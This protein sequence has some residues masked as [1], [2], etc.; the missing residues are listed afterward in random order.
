MNCDSG[1]YC[2]GEYAEGICEGCAGIDMPCSNGLECCWGNH[3][4]PE[5]PVV[6]PT[7]SWACLEMS[8]EL[9]TPG[10]ADGSMRFWVDDEL[11]HEATGIRWRDGSQLQLNRAMLEHYIAPGDT[12]HP[13]EAWF[14]DVIVSTERIGCGVPPGGDTSTGGGEDSGGET[15]GDDGPDPDPGGETTSTTGSAAPTT[16]GTSGQAPP[17]GSD[18]SSDGDTESTSAAQGSS[19]CAVGGHGAPA[20]WLGLLLLLGRWC[21]RSRS[22]IRW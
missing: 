9:N 7:E 13:N 3:F 18:P 15:T 12:D 14:D 17:P 8:M 4:S 16:D 19:G 20:G 5:V 10:V 21:R 11:G 22:S 2:S 6:L 1:G